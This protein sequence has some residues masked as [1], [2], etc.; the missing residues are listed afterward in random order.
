MKA[1]TRIDDNLP[2]KMTAHAVR[3]LVACD[4]CAG[5]G[6]RSLMILGATHT[7]CAAVTMTSNEL[8]RLSNKERGKFRLCDLDGLSASKREAILGGV[9]I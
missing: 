8:R 9:A 4:K 5:M 2:V 1:A 7:S 6:D 3:R